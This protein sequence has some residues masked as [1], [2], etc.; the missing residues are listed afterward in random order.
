M[1]VS[2]KKNKRPVTSAEVP[3]K[4]L[5]K[6]SRVELLEILVEQSE[7]IDKLRLEL[8]ETKAQ[9]DE[10]QIAIDSSG[11][12]A[13]AALKINKLFESADAAAKQ[14]LENM[15][16]LAG[17]QQP[18]DQLAADQAEISDAKRQ[19]AVIITN[20]SLEASNI[21][22]KAKLQAAQITADAESEAQAASAAKASHRSVS[23][24]ANV[25]KAAGARSRRTAASI[26]SARGGAR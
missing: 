2:S 23:A 17:K 10:R 25:G 9:L 16:S 6:L 24:N 4:D 8:K 1:G 13:E 3:T 12:L 15:V 7:E 11:S 5:R 18:G 19:A 14:Y 21:L 22:T 20:A 26:F